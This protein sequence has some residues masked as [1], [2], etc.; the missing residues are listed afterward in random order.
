MIETANDRSGNN[1]VAVG[2]LVDE[3]TLPLLHK[4]VASV[5]VLSENIF[6]L[7]VGENC[8]VTEPGIIV[9][10]G[11]QADDEAASRNLLINHV[12]KANVAEYLVWLNPGEEFDVKTLDEFQQFLE[13]DCQRDCL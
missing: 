2:I 3:R 8:T 7:T 1:S 4:T 13:H 12:E 9:Y 5:Q 10:D 11:G 6:V